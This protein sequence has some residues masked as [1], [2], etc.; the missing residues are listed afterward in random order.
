[1]TNCA[2]KEMGRINNQVFSYWY[3]MY[4]ELVFYSYVTNNHK[5]SGLKKKLFISSQFPWIR[6][7]IQVSWV[8]C[9]GSQGSNEDRVLIGKLNQGNTCFQAH[10]GSWQNSFPMIIRQR[11]FLM[12]VGSPGVHT[13]PCQWPSP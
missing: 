12:A 6:S 11:V 2:M 10:S 3:G 5:Y 13:A 8:L 9:L 1:M 7:P 4:S